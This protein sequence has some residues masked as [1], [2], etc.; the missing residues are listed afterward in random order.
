MSASEF[1]G[2]FVAAMT[3]RHLRNPILF[4]FINLL[5]FASFCF[6]VFVHTEIA[7][8]PESRSESRVRLKR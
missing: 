6:S 2:G 1:S 3:R 5:I 4:E 8:R 7:V